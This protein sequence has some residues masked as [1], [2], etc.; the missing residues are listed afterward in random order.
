M[1]NPHHL[2]IFSDVVDAGGMSEAA[3]KLNL[4]YSAINKA[5]CALEENLG[6]KLFTRQGP[7]KLTQFGLRWYEPVANYHNLIRRLS[8]RARTEKD[9]TFVLGGSEYV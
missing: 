8:A 4:T 1:P 5:M 9:Y 2:E 6:G 7:F 3:K